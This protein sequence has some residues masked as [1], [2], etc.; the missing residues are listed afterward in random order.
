MFVASDRE[1]A[2]DQMRA[3]KAVCRDCS[4]VND[5]LAYAI[6]SQVAF[7]IWGGLTID[8]LQSVRSTRLLKPTALGA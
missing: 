2:P 6:T 3:A 5:C 7:G 8:E 4:V 1:M